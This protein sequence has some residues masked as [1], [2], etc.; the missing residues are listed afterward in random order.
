MIILQNCMYFYIYM[1]IYTFNLTQIGDILISLSSLR[2]MHQEPVFSQTFLSKMNFIKRH[3]FS[4]EQ[5]QRSLSSTQ[6]F[7]ALPLLPCVIPLFLSFSLFLKHTF[8]LISSKLEWYGKCK[9]IFIFFWHQC[10][11]IKKCL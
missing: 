6:S 4:C 9:Q 7:H 1:Y 2:G 11:K 3:F 10:T 5:V 8:I